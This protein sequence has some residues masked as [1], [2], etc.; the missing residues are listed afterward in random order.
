MNGTIWFLLLI[1]LLL[2]IDTYTALRGHPRKK[3]TQ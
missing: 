2:A 1:I 3:G